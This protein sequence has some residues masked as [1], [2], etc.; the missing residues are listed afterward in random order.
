M[1]FPHYCKSL[2]FINY[3]Q[4]LQ[5]KWRVQYDFKSTASVFTNIIH[6]VPEINSTLQN[7]DLLSPCNWLH[8]SEGVQGRAKDGNGA[9]G[10]NE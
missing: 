7:Q 9:S 6:V 3:V 2:S 5:R 10:Q 1:H 4:I 8:A